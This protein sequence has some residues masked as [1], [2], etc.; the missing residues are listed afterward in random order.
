MSTYV[1]E[2]ADHALQVASHK[3]AGKLLAVEACTSSSAVE[4]VA[5]YADSDNEKLGGWFRTAMCLLP[6]QMS[7]YGRIRSPNRR[8]IGLLNSVIAAK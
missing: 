4:V 3:P 6:L 5:A 8:G 1:G 2:L 7:R